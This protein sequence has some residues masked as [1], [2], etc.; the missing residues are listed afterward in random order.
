MV[1]QEHR[2]SVSQ[3]GDIRQ[4]HWMKGMQMSILSVPLLRETSV[5]RDQ[6]VG[7]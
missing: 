7:F 1:R 4:E 2:A 5:G 6:N 3:R